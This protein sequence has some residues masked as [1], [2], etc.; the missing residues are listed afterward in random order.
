MGFR[1]VII[2]NRAKLDVRLNSL[3]VRGEQEKKVFSSSVPD[4]SNETITTPPTKT[5]KKYQFVDVIAV[6]QDVNFDQPKDDVPKK[7]LPWY[8]RIFS[9]IFRRKK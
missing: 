5:G 7:Q 6:I 3:I 4:I 9:R 1:T 8:K 2:K